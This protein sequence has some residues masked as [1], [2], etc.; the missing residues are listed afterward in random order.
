MSNSQ[1]S[2]RTDDRPIA[3]RPGSS[4]G[5]PTGSRPIERPFGV[6][7]SAQG[8]FSRRPNMTIN[9]NIAWQ[10]R[11]ETKAQAPWA[12]PADFIPRSSGFT[13]SSGAP[14]R[15]YRSYQ[16]L[17]SLGGSSRYGI[18]SAKRDGFRDAGVEAALLSASVN[19]SLL[20]LPAHPQ[21]K[22][23]DS[24]DRL[25]GESKT[26]KPRPNS[27]RYTLIPNPDGRIPLLTLEHERYL[28]I[29][30]P[31]QSGPLVHARKTLQ[32]FR[33]AFTRDPPELRFPRGQAQVDIVAGYLMIPC[34]T[35]LEGSMTTHFVRH[36]DDSLRAWA[37]VMSPRDDPSPSTQAERWNMVEA[38]RRVRHQAKLVEKFNESWD[39]WV[40]EQSEEIQKAARRDPSGEKVQSGTRAPFR[41]YYHY[42]L[43]AADGELMQ[44][45]DIAEA[46]ILQYAYCFP[47]FMRSFE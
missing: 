8:E 5:A 33:G 14:Q 17:P 19:S 44:R 23:L 42:M 45:K 22:I 15:S 6:T 24:F 29:S 26:L 46:L 7:A 32:A 27:P 43:I 10:P 12:S 47:G 34:S 2:R 25:P 11:H 35:R 40:S 16:S 28:E 36:S 30:E 18:T 9:T 37:A 38:R 4:R 31:L 39:S 41:D 1:Q 3:P 13:P 21:A 20:D